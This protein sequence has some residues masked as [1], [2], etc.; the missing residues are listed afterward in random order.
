MSLVTLCICVFFVF[1]LCVFFRA[2]S[3]SFCHFRTL[4]IGHRFESWP[5]YIRRWIWIRHRCRTCWMSVGF[6]HRMLRKSFASVDLVDAC[7]WR[8][9]CGPR[10]RIRWN[11]IGW[12][13]R[14]RSPCTSRMMITWRKHRAYCLTL[15]KCAR[16]WRL[17]GRRTGCCARPWSSRRGCNKMCWP[18]RT[19]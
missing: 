5:L 11:W 19:V 9:C 18:G 10:H 2:R 12:F 8:G 17:C 14:E 6:R 16:R 13:S 1:G 15:R 3:L 4:L 7:T